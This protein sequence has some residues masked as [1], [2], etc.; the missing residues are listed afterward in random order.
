[1]ERARPP[2]KTEVVWMMYPP[3]QAPPVLL[4]ANSRSY[5][6]TSRA[7]GSGG[8]SAPATLRTALTR[9]SLLGFPAGR[10]SLA[11]RL[12]LDAV[13]PGECTSAEMDRS[14]PGLADDALRGGDTRRRTL[15]CSSYRLT[16][17]DSWCYS[18]TSWRAVRSF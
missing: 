15:A 16:M 17:S 6:I 11:R 4:V 8:P 13:I 9:F 2:L 7:P 3:Y 10:G 14:G 18:A 12:F 5:V 1:M